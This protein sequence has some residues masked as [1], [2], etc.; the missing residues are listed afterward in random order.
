MAASKPEKLI[1]QLLDE[2]ET[3]FRRLDL[4]FRGSAFERDRFKYCPTKPEGG[5]SNMTASKPKILISQLSDEIE[6]KLQRI[7]IS[8]RGPAFELH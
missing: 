8:F 7:K 6:T 5:K 3:K 1:S 2:I 4:H